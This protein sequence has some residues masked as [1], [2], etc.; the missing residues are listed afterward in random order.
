MLGEVSWHSLLGLLM[1][2]S[3]GGCKTAS[4]AISLLSRDRRM[5]RVSQKR[6][7]RRRSNRLVKEP[8]V[9]RAWLRRW[10]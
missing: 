4:R 1:S 3:G 5:P 10:L 7:R 9:R 6:G 8:K 2:L